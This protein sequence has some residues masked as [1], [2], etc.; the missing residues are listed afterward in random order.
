MK[1]FKN[2]IVQ[3]G[4]I[5]TILFMSSGPA[6]A[7]TIVYDFVTTLELVSGPDTNG[8]NGATVS[9]T[10][11]FDDSSVYVDLFG[12]PAIDSISH[13][14]TISGA[15]VAASNGVFVDPDGLTYFPT[16]SNSFETN[17]GAFL[18]VGP[19][20]L[21]AMETGPGAVVPLLGDT[22]SLDHFNTTDFD[23]RDLL[24]ES[25]VGFST[26]SWAD[27]ASASVAA[28]VPVPA[29]LWLMLGGLAS[30]VGFGRK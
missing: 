26:Y 9:I 7:G 5:V 6:F 13:S 15:T 25:E 10:A 28:V 17:G 4:L 1:M 11:S 2:Q 14:I 23:P 20:N 27:N 21:V 12:L 24:M 30:L 22:I 18:A 16:F 19:L 8:L 3:A 29:A